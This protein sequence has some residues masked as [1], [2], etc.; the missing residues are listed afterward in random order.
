M[1]TETIV[2]TL[3][4]FDELNEE[5]KEKAREWYRN[6]ALDYEWWDGIYDDAATVGLKIASFGLDRRKGVEGKLTMSIVESCKA[7]LKE[8]GPDC[9]TYKLAGD[10]LKAFNAL[11]NAK[12]EAIQDMTVEDID[13]EKETDIL[14]HFKTDVED[15]QDQYVYALREEYASILQRE[16]EYL[17]SDECVDGTIEANEYEFTESGKCA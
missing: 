14:E 3:Y 13:N 8:H 7:I 10:F 12:D 11:D 9:D 5:A 17:L 15:L 16:Y 6:G 1:R 2:R 4:R